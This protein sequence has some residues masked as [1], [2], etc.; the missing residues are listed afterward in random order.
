MVFLVNHLTATGSLREPLSVFGLAGGTA[1]IRGVSVLSAGETRFRHLSGYSS[2]CSIP[3][4]E[5]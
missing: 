5:I 3:H 1:L 2:N 4:A